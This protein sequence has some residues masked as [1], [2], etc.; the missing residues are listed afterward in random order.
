[1]KLHGQKVY[2]KDAKKIPSRNKF[3]NAKE[4]REVQFA[5]SKGHPLSFM[6][7]G[8]YEYALQESTYEKAKYVILLTG[9]FPD[10]QK[11]YVLIKNAP[12]FI[13]IKLDENGTDAQVAEI[14]DILNSVNSK[15]KPEREIIKKKPFRYFQEEY[16]SYLRVYFYKLK[17][18]RL[19]LNELIDRR[20]ATGHDDKT[21]YFRVVCR[22]YMITFSDWSS[23]QNYEVKTFDMFK[24]PV[25]Y[26]D[27]KDYA[28]YKGIRTNQ[29]NF[30]KTMSM[31]WDIETY[32]TSRD[33]EVPLPET[34]D[35][36]MFM[37]SMTFQ[38][39]HSPDAILK[40]ILVDKPTARHPDYLTIVCGNEKGIINT[41]GI[42][43]SKMMPEYVVGFNDQSYD[44]PWLVERAFQL[45]NGT[46]TRLVNNMNCINPYHQTTDDSVMKY[47]YNTISVKLAADAPK[48]PHSFLGIPGFIALDTRTAFRKIYP[49]AEKSSLGYFL[50]INGLAGK[51]DMP[52][53]VLFGIRGDCLFLYDDKNRS[54][55][56]ESLNEVKTIPE[57]IKFLNAC[58][59]YDLPAYPHEVNR[60]GDLSCLPRQI[61]KICRHHKIDET[62]LDRSK[63]K[64]ISM[65]LVWKHSERSAVDGEQSPIK[66]FESNPIIFIPLVDKILTLKKEMAEISNYCVVDSFRCHQL[67]C[68]RS[69]IP[70]RREIANLTYTSVFEAVFRANGAKA[71]NLTI[72]DAQ[73][74]GYSVSNIVSGEFIPEGKYSGGAVLAP[75]YGM[76]CPKATIPERIAKAIKIQFENTDTSGN[77]LLDAELKKYE[78]WLNVDKSKVDEYMGIIRKYG[79]HVPDKSTIREIEHIEDIKFDQCFIDFLTDKM[80]RPITG[81]DFSSLYPSLIMVYNLSP[82]CMIIDDI[83]ALHLFRKGIKLNKIS[84]MDNGKKTKAWSV[85]HCG[86]VDIKTQDCQMGQL[87]RTL[88]RLY[89]KR[90]AIRAPLNILK[91]ADKDRWKSLLNSTKS[92]EKWD[93]TNWA[94]RKKFIEDNGFLWKE[95]V[96][97]WEEKKEMMDD[98]RGM[99]K[100][101]EFVKEYLSICFW[102]NSINSKQKALKVIMNTFYGETGCKSS[103]FYMR[104]ISSGI[105]AMGQKNIMFAKKIVKSQLWHVIYGDTDSLYIHPDHV[106]FKRLDIEYYTGKMSK[107]NYVTGSVNKVFEI[108]GGLR[109]YVNNQFFEDNGTRILKMAFEEVLF[110][111]AF[112]AKKKYYGIAHVHFPNFS[113]N[114]L[115]IRGLGIIKRGASDFMKEIYSEVMWKSVAIEN[116]DSLIEL[117][118]IGIRDLYS[119]SWSVEKF[120]KSA[121]YKLPRPG[122][123]GNIKVLRFVERMKEINV[124]IKVG[125]RFN[126]VICKKPPV[127]DYRGRSVAIKT[128]DR[129]EL[130][131]RVV[132]NNMEV[133]MDYCVEKEIAGQFS[134]LII[135][136]EAF[137]MPAPPDATIDELKKIDT[138]ML[139][140]AKKYVITL[141]NKYSSG[142]VDKNKYYK[143]IFSTASKITSVNLTEAYRK[144]G[145]VSD[146]TIKALGGSWT[147]G[148]IGGWLLNNAEAEAKS[149]IRKHK[150]GI[151]SKNCYYKSMVVMSIDFELNFHRKQYPDMPIDKKLVASIKKKVVSAISD[152]YLGM[153]GLHAMNMAAY[154]TRKRLLIKSLQ[155]NKEDL[156]EVYD[157]YNGLTE[158]TAKTL[159]SKTGIDAKFNEERMRCDIPDITKAEINRVP[160]LVD[161]DMS[162][163]IDDAINSLIAKSKFPRLIAKL[164]SIRIQIISNEIFIKKS[165]LIVDFV[166]ARRK[167][168]AGVSKN[169]LM[170][171]ASELTKRMVSS[172]N[173]VY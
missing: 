89:L 112:L 115:F 63:V 66:G 53:N 168:S 88:M 154:N 150:L 87:G 85:A 133:D 158:L 8:V 44:W 13:D 170:T 31:T 76:N 47:T 1:M 159:K 122:M 78:G 32:R 132:E 18:R 46:L 70:D 93:N 129:M 164:N 40:V 15:P 106:E 23:I 148:D 160:D 131:D 48:A 4:Y 62:S 113:P 163:T 28:K 68:K 6:P 152:N 86:K 166:E 99:E 111:S 156:R 130:L 137:F 92:D 79:P 26:V 157:M 114:E 61:S 125:E 141:I 34:R 65:L 110:F 90:K 29:M 94:T 71:R 64:L 139:D 3:L 147:D 52:Y 120:A 172:T 73:Q 25:Y 101:V 33:G 143:K 171:A 145:G 67:L 161:D 51:E 14:I 37:I 5:I 36:I 117:V 104:A 59:Y 127:Y 126:Y 153:N 17:D 169:T 142:F 54:K 56:P 10:G 108:I 91:D 55:M 103:P 12:V 35:D 146:T 162:L 102:V 134:R 123:P 22:D 21:N 167:K 69:V 38:W 74:R 72:A 41:F 11:A 116:T 39:I 155:D 98:Q 136:H 149:Y 83:Y 49:T 140:R 27:I 60:T 109:D 30:D 19:G 144:I 124:K 45:S 135:Y 58:N 20:M 7:T 50:E 97:G 105:T 173:N 82:E 107:L 2:A 80:G 16:S 96:I 9:V 100:D 165:Q 95:T 118:N 43:F 81:L 77:E 121:V 128:G 84:Y 24:F 119:K 57:F 42:M 75:D 138:K 151:G